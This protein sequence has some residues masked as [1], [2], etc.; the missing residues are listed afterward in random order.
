MAEFNETLLQAFPKLQLAGG[1]E[2]LKCASSTR[3]LEVIPLTIS[4]S[5]RQL[6]AYIGTA[7][8][9]IRPIQADLDLTPPEGIDDH[10]V[11]KINI[12]SLHSYVII[13]SFMQADVKQECLQCGESIPII[14]LR[15]HVKNCQLRYTQCS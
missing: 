9:Y 13:T 10:I 3:M 12:K 6:K 14:Q 2:M 15:D 1:F 7:R 5:A 4:S 11:R 8:I